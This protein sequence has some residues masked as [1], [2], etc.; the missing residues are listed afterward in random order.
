MVYKLDQQYQRETDTDVGST[1]ARRQYQDLASNSIK[2]RELVNQTLALTKSERKGEESWL[3]KERESSIAP[4]AKEGGPGNGDAIR[5]SLEKIQL[6]FSGSQV[7]AGF[8]HSGR[9]WRRG[10]K[11]GE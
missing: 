10:R 1:T 5:K 8:R 11:K 9:S 3:K 6:V 2:S 7:T 4:A